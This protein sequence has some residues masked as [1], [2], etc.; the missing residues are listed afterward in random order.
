MGGERHAA[1]ADTNA[2]T[3][4]DAN[5]YTDAYTDA[6][7]NAYTD[8]D[9]DAN[10]NANANANRRP[11]DRFIL[12]RNGACTAACYEVADIHTGRR[13]STACRPALPTSSRSSTRLRQ[14]L[15]QNGGYECDMV[16]RTEVGND[17]PTSPAA[18]TGG[19]AYA[20]YQRSPGRTVNGQAVPW[21]AR[22][23][24]ISCN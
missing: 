18:G 5:A 17:N 6:N 23:A 20:D 9:A 3:H 16:T 19:D 10:A 1:N 4:S 21:D 12:S 7:A 22:S 2:D 11:R 24:A 14:Y 8:A 15:R 13:W